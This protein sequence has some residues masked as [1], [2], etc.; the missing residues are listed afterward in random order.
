[1]IS[2]ALILVLGVSSLS[3]AEP[4]S[5]QD[6]GRPSELVDAITGAVRDNLSRAVLPD[7][8]NVPAET[9]EERARPLISRNL[10]LAT[11]DRALLSATMEVCGLDYSA[12]S[13]RPFMSALRES[14]R[15]S[16]KQMAYIGLLHGFSSASFIKTFDASKCSDEL[17]ESMI[18]TAK[19]LPIS[20]P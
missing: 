18:E 7:G 9:P 5:A 4:I 12:I 16:Q 11:I 8:S 17:T 2:K 15:F 6:D 10:E 14:G 1:M 3:V 19:D 13:Y 20:S